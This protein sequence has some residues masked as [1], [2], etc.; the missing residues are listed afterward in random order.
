ML[1]Y[2]IFK[3]TLFT[4]WFQVVVITGA[5]SG[6]GEA[7]A[8]EFYRR[9]C[10]VVLCARRKDE[11]DRV[12]T[13]LLHSHCNVH[14]HSPIVMPLDL[15]DLDSLPQVI[16]NVTTITGHIDILINNGGISNRG[17]VL[18]KNISVDLKVM[19]V[20]YFGTVALTKGN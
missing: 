20:N 1:P 13:D 7:I 9:G 16:Q 18:D 3:N 4:V 19:Q 15:S 10:L 12:R 17:T 6:L 5:S 2:K 14:T 8:H 11:L